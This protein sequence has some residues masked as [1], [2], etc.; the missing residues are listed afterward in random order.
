MKSQMKTDLQLLFCCFPFLLYS[1]FCALIQYFLTLTLFFLFYVC[2][3]SL[4]LC[5]DPSDS[6]TIHVLPFRFLF[7]CVC[8]VVFLKKKSE[9]RTGSNNKK[10]CVDFQ[11]KK[12]K[13]KILSLLSLSLLLFNDCH[14]H[15][16][17]CSL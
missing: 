10:L 9:F 15:V 8:I 3:L 16:C 11:K 2:V 5:S 6:F 1:N 4:S 7:L 12:I 13:K 17:V 14:H